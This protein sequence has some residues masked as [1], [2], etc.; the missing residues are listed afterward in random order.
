MSVIMTEKV[1]WD[2]ARG[3]T[4]TQKNKVYQGSETQ[5]TKDMVWKAGRRIRWGGV[6]TE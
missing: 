3:R 2:N 1:D 6:S 5:V 4:S